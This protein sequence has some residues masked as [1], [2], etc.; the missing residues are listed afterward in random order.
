MCSMLINR[1]SRFLKQGLGQLDQQEKD[2]M[3]NLANSLLQ[4]QNGNSAQNPAKK[5]HKE[6]KTDDFCPKSSE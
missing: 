3:E 5:R 4:V 1:N 2:Y 6:E